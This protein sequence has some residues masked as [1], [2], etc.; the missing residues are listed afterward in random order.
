LIVCGSTGPEEEA[1]F[2]QHLA[3]LT[4]PGPDGQSRPVQL[5]IAPRKPERFD[6]A[7]EAMGRP[8]RRTEHP[9]GTG[10]PEGKGDASLFLLDTLGELGKAYALADVVV[11]GRSFCGLYGSDMTEPIA[12][13]KPTL[14]G[15]ETADFREMTRHLLAG[16][17][18]IQV[19]TLSELRENVA[20]LLGDPDRAAEI[21]RR[22]RDVIRAQQGATDRHA[23]LLRELLPLSA[24]PSADEP[25]A[26]RVERRG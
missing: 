22:G 12:L 19:A 14:I 4:V 15:P 7:A 11:V 6:E 21:A 9:D 25:A 26:E 1:M 23:E 5:L 16:G 13:G 17:G 2:V 10:P 20:E 18:L 3:D 8:V 24:G